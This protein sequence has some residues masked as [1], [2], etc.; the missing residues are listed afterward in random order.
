MPKGVTFLVG[1]LFL[2]FIIELNAD[3]IDESR[4]WGNVTDQVTNRYVLKAFKFYI[5]I[6]LM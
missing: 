4:K 3:P 1:I 2:V 5:K 6:I